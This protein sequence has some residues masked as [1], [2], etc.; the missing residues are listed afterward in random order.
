MFMKSSFSVAALAAVTM[1]GGLALSTASAQITIPTV[2]IGN[3]GNAPDPLTGRGTV[4]YTYNIGTTEVTNAQYAA[5]LTAKAASDPFALWNDRMG[6][7]RSGLEGAYTYSAV[8]SRANQPVNYVSFYNAARFANWLHNGQGSG[9]TETGAYT[10]GGV[11][12]PTNLTRNAG[13]QWAVTSE[14][15]WYKAAYFQLAAQ[16]GDADNYWWYPTSSNTVPTTA[17][18]NFNNVIGDITPVGSYAPNFNGLFDMGGNLDEWNDTFHSSDPFRVR[19]G[20][21][22]LNF[23]F[24]L[25]SDIRNDLD[26]SFAGN[27]IGFRVVQIPGP[28]SVALLA[29]GGLV[30]TRRRR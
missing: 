13:A 15:E 1:A 12:R 30:T 18:G 3:P 7:T 16:G 21:N 9:D 14:N 17:Q 20:G 25:R 27:F 6:I 8:N 24:N 22:F 4:D 11:F 10:L 26:G 28:S 5:F 29:I 23:D 19:R 2:T